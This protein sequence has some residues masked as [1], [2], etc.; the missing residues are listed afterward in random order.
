[1]DKDVTIDVIFSDKYYNKQ[2]QEQ[3][4]DLITKWNIY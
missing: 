4:C 1:M 2:N 3:I